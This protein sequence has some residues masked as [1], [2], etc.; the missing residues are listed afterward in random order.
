MKPILS[1]TLIV[2]ILFFSLFSCRKKK[3][4]PPIPPQK[5]AQIIVDI[6][7]AES[8]SKGLDADKDS[9]L[10]HFTKNTDSLYRFY[11]SILHHYN[12]S[13]ENFNDAVVWYQNHP[14]NMDSLLN[15]SIGYLN[16]QKAE[17]GLQNNPNLRLG[18]DENGQLIPNDTLLPQGEP[19]RKDSSIT[20]RVESKHTKNG[21]TK[22]AEHSQKTKEI[23]QH[24]K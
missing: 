6:Q 19:L 15:L 5:L 12:L 22:P 11:S 24:E 4:N 20:E 10:T 16:R 7:I 9:S 3:E 18:S 13:L 8:Y 14:N 21:T 2:V 17:L 23:N 1:N